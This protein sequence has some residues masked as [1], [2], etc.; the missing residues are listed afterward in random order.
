MPSLKNKNREM[1]RWGGGE[2]KFFT[3]S[4]DLHISPSPHLLTFLDLRAMECYF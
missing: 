3:P 1:K 4:S 2:K